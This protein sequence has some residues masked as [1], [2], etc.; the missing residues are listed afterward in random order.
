MEGFNESHNN[1]LVYCQILGFQGTQSPFCLRRILKAFIGQQLFQE[2]IAR[3]LNTSKKPKLE[4]TL[5]RL[6]LHSSTHK[7]YSLRCL[8]KLAHIN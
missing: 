3:G 2:R 4:Q 6:A 8:N 5:T 1:Y 7:A